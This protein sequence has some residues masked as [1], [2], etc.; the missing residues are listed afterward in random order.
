M[1]RA[2][3]RRIFVYYQSYEFAKAYEISF[4]FAQI[5]QTHCITVEKYEFMG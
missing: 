5:L 2:E 3:R 4:S 1:L